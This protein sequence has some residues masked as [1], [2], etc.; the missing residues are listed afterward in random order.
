V[1]WLIGVALHRDKILL[2]WRG[3]QTLQQIGDSFGVTRERVRQ[4][5]R[6]WGETVNTG[7]HKVRAK[8][9]GLARLAQR[10]SRYIA[11]Y[12]MSH[13]QFKATPRAI[14]MA[15]IRQ[16]RTARSRGI[17][18]NLTFAEWL[19]IWSTSGKLA[20]RG[21]NKGQYVMARLRDAGPYA[22]G[23][24][25]IILGADNIRQ[26]RAHSRKLR[27]ANGGYRGIHLL[28]PGT[29]KP[30]VVQLGGKVRG[31][32]ATLAEARSGRKALV[33]SQ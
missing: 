9:R 30:Y 24:V 5:L 4:L 3:G 18:W 2:M 7:G 11:R 16:R 12:G 10:D 22:I 28:Y 20:L 6:K 8:Q 26:A 23:N 33:A 14:F 1:S 15:F 31:Y 21:R 25:E 27:K 17:G 19:A 29:K 32:F 13:A